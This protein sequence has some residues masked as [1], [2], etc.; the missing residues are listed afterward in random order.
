MTLG[1]FTAHLRIS[2][3]RIASGF[4]EVG[5]T[6]FMLKWRWKESFQLFIMAA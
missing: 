3:A 2:R 1:G 4:D 5:E 6:I